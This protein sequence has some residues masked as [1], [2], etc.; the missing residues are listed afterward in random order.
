MPPPSHPKW[1]KLITMNHR[2][3]VLPCVLLSLLGCASQST[4]TMASLD[5]MHPLFN[6]EECKAMRKQVW[7]HQDLKNARTVGGPAVVVLAGPLA[8]IPVLAVNV[9]MGAADHSDAAKL[10]AACGGKK[11][12]DVD[13][14]TGVAIETGIGVAAGAVIPVSGR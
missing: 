2:W 12:S 9:S 11:V 7:V 14:A 5:P 4:R 3:V 10:S 6:S 1:C 8:V 13:V